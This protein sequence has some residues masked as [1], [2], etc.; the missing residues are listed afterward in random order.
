[1]PEDV[2]REI[3]VE[4]EDDGAARERELVTES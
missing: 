3:D 1:V 2:D 4:A